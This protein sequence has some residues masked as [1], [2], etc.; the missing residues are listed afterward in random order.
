MVVAHLDEADEVVDELLT[1]G[2]DAA[3]FPALEVLP[4]ESN[5]S[6]E[7]LAERLR[8]QRRLV[9]GDSP[10]VLVA[11][12]PALMQLVPEPARLDRLLY[13]IQTGDAIG[14]SALIRWLVD[15]GFSRVDTIENPGEFSVRGG[16]LDLYPPGGG[17]P[18]RLDFFGD[19]VEAIYEIDLDTMGNDRKTDS[20]ELIGANMAAAQSDHESQSL[21]ECL[22]KDSIAVLAELLEIS[23]QGRGYYERLTDATGIASTTSVFSRLNSRLHAVIDVNQFGRGA[24]ASRSVEWPVRA[25]PTFSEGTSEAVAELRQIADER[26]VTVCAQTPGEAQRLEELLS[27]D[28]GRPLSLSIEVRYLHRGF[29]FDGENGLCAFVPYHELVHRYHTRRA[30]R[31][32]PPARALDAFLDI[33]PGDLVVHREHGIAR[34]IAFGPLKDEK[35]RQARGS[36][37]YLTLEFDGGS[38]LFVP[39][40]EVSLIQRYVGAFQGTPTLSKLGGKRWKKQKDDVAEAVRDLA[41]EMLR[42]QAVRSSASGIHYPHDTTWQKEF[43]AEFPYEETDDQL[44][45]ISAVKRDMSRDQPMDRL[46]CGDVGFG[47]TEVAIRAAFKAAEYGK[48]V[49]VLVPTTILAEQHERTFRERFAGYPMRIESISRFKT[50][51]E[52]NA[53]LKDVAAGR[54]DIIIGTHRLLSK[55]VRFADVGLVIVDEEQRFG[56]EHKH[57][58]L[59]FRLTA[60]VL[61]LSATPIPRTLHMAMLGLRDISSLS[62]PPADRRSIVTEVIPYEPRRITQAIHRELAREGQIFFVHNRVH[63]IESVADDIQKLAPDAR[64]VIGHGQMSSRELE[65]VMLAFVRRQADILISTTIIESGVDIPTA[66]TMFINNADHFGLSELHQLRG[67]VGRYKHRA[68]CYLLLP[69]DRTMTETAIRRLRAI[70]EYAMLGAGFK[71]AMRDLE[72]RGAGNLLG[73]EQSGHI[74]AV[75]YEMY[76]E[77]LQ[78]AVRELRKE[79]RT[80][81]AETIIDVGFTGALT[82]QYIPSDQRRLDAYR[83]LSEVGTPADLDHVRRDL[84]EAYG[85]PP[86]SAA[87]MLDLAELRSL[88]AQNAIHSITRHG[89]DLIFRTRDAGLLEARMH[90]IMGSLRA[91]GQPDEN[92]LMTIYFRPPKAYLEPRTL[93]SVLRKRLAAPLTPT[94]AHA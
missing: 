18:V 50:K 30:V 81:R 47:K 89:D 41:G 31:R 35:L 65:K 6:L 90:G 52:Q 38:R 17:V 46:I 72:I 43:E 87:L 10:A 92:G 27:G 85:E 44:A 67:R 33:E 71:I 69:P 60:D 16:I 36:Q 88:A 37:E 13:P 62:T 66:N 94:D 1:L 58:L 84:T 59:Q 20:I 51:K 24:N 8:L 21:I 9:R 73:A 11:P 57:R 75:G 2:I 64:I 49:A 4:G 86:E 56:V 12:I 3:R 68:Y 40:T 28:G 91:V 79:P 29:L 54:V 15:S 70:E 14:Q 53:V 74:S 55:D 25:L 76:C 19:D 45:A 61:T 63:N 48:Q 82:K 22:P 78:Q 93:L 83:R 26:R 39:A 77:L 5:V 23:E 34:F 80:H 7:L 32:M 42:M